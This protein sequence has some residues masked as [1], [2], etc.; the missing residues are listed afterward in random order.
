MHHIN[1]IIFI[2]CRYQF[3]FFFNKKSTY[4]DIYDKS[5]FKINENADLTNW[6]NST[7][8]SVMMQEERASPDTDMKN[9]GF[10]DLLGV[11]KSRKC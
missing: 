2:I 3:R 6:L 9:G 7:N 11:G 8:D 4:S 1:Y 5:L 10:R